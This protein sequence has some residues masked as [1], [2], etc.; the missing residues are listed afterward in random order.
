MGKTGGGRG[1]NQ[2]RVR[3]RSVGPGRRDEP[4]GGT[5]SLTRVPPAPTGDLDTDL[6][7]VAEHLPAGTAQAWRALVPVLPDTAY[8]AGGTALTC[9][10]GHRTSRDLDFF[11]AEP[12]DVDGLRRA[13]DQ[14][15]TF[16]P[17]LVAPGTLN[18]VLGSTKVQFLEASTQHHV[19]E[20]VPFA[21]LRIASIPDLLA[22]KLKVIGDRAEL[23]D[24]F[25]VMVID[26]VTAWSVEVGLRLFVD[27]YQPAA[28]DQAVEH[29]LRGLGYTDDVLPDPG[30][31]VARDEVVA[32]W[33]RRVRDLRP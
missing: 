27:R 16:A 12:F 14:V 23:R 31:P 22:M 2:H 15:G 4:A 33:A 5:L 19:A 9:H 32:F 11:F 26:Q 13:V 7:A 25:D 24:Y 29:I 28:P 18:G 3:G 30:L 20:P 21:G 10:L 8:L 6:A 17:T 1:T